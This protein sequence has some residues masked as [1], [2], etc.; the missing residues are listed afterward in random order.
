VIL[1]S[2]PDAAQLVDPT[3]T[4]PLPSSFKASS[5]DFDGSVCLFGCE[6]V[7]YAKVCY[8]GGAVVSDT[9]MKGSCDA[10]AKFL[11]VKQDGVWVEVNGQLFV[12]H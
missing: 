1:T 4:L 8:G 7:D 6:G 5:T 9:R 11:N 2:A 12:F 3:T 10:S